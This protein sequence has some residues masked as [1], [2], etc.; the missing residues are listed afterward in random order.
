MRNSGGWTC[1]MSGVVLN[2]PMDV[3]RVHS[4]RIPEDIE[5]A[6]KLAGKFVCEEQAR[7]LRRAGFV[8]FNWGKHLERKQE[9]AKTTIAEMLASKDNGKSLRELVKAKA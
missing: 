8:V 7:L 1:Y 2:D 5:N 4:G 9:T 6:E 3:Y